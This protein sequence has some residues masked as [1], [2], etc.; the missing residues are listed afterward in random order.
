[1]CW[2]KPYHDTPLTF[3]A[4]ITPNQQLWLIGTIQDVLELERIGIR[5]SLR[6][7]P[8]LSDGPSILDG[9][10]STLNVSAAGDWSVGQPP[11]RGLA[12]GRLGNVTGYFLQ[13]KGGF[14]FTSELDLLGKRKQ[15]KG[16]VGPTGRS[17]DVLYSRMKSSLVLEPYNMSSIWG[18]EP[19]SL[20]P[21][22]PQS[23]QSLAA[24]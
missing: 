8:V 1:M 14:C 22:F 3:R 23:Q 24:S 12:S 2:T 6:S 9:P 11:T 20:E 19:L 21:C 16:W 18:E 5:F 13:N 15:A 10:N 7:D 4:F 17:G